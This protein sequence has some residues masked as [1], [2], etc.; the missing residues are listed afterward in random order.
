[1]VAT[2][3]RKTCFTSSSVPGVAWQIPPHARRG[4]SDAC[5]ESGATERLKSASSCWAKRSWSASGIASSCV[6]RVSA[7]RSPVSAQS[8]NERI[9]ITEKRN[10]PMVLVSFIVG[11]VGLILHVIG[12]IPLVGIVLSGIVLASFKPETQKNRWMAGWAWP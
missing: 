1:M 4:G 6:A 7:R 12:L 2:I 5:Y 3:S 11:I 10:N 9:P 8:G